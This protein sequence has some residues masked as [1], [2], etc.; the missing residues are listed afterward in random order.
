MLKLIIEI[1]RRGLGHIAS[2]T[3]LPILKN[4]GHTAVYIVHC[5][6]RRSMRNLAATAKHTASNTRWRFNA[7]A[8]AKRPY[9]QP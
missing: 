7:I 3:V 4:A 9:L 6:K 8:P 1:T 5:I 2:T